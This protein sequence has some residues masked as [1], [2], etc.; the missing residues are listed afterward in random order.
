MAGGGTGPGCA[1]CAKSAMEPFAYRKS[2][3]VFGMA[4]T[5]VEFMQHACTYRVALRLYVSKPATLV[6]QTGTQPAS[7]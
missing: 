5:S 1:L 4:G 7:H 6:G 3:S 2:A